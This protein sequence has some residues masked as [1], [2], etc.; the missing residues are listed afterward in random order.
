M[1]YQKCALTDNGNNAVQRRSPF[2]SWWSLTNESSGCVCFCLLL[3]VFLGGGGEGVCFLVV[4][5]CLFVLG[6]LV[7]VCV[8]VCV[9]VRVC[10]D[11]NKTDWICIELSQQFWTNNIKPGH[12]AEHVFEEL[13]SLCFCHYVTVLFAG[14]CGK[15]VR[16]WCDGSSDR[17]FMGWTLWA[18]SRSSQCSTTSVTKAVVCIILSVGWCI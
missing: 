16:S 13:V 8:C 7:E 5:C 3:L 11:N 12:I 9:C 6:F 2:L 15:S 4:W 17:P 1:K 18:I 14:L 10:V